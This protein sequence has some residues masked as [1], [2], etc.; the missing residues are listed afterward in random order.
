MMLAEESYLANAIRFAMDATRVHDWPD[1][2]GYTTHL[3]NV[4]QELGH[5]AVKL[6]RANNPSEFLN[7][8]SDFWTSNGLGE[9]SITQG[10]SFII[11]IKRCY[12]CSSPKVGPRHTSCNFKRAFLKTVFEDVFN[13][14]VNITERE[15]CGSQAR[16]CRFDV[17]IV[18]N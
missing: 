17:A 5:E 16:R 14:S 8:F 7:R 1:P 10:D 18:T 2:S 15:C 4:G 6:L 9:M 12:D 11:E 3:T 13:H